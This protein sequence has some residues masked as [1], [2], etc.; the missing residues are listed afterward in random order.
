[1]LRIRNNF[2]L[3]M[4]LTLFLGMEVGWSQTVEAENEIKLSRKARKGSLASFQRADNGDITLLY[5]TRKK[6]KS[7]QYEVYVIDGK[8]YEQKSHETK[9]VSVDDFKAEF[10]T[11][12][13]VKEEYSETGIAVKGYLPEAG[14]FNVGN[15]SAG[16]QIVGAYRAAFAQVFKGLELQKFRIDYEFNWEEG[17]YYYSVEELDDINPRYGEDELKLEHYDNYQVEQNGEYHL[18]VLAGERSPVGF[19]AARSGNLDPDQVKKNL[20]LLTFNP[21][22][23]MTSDVELFYDDPYTYRHGNF[24]NGNT[25]YAM[26]LTAP[27][28]K[29]QGTESDAELVIANLDGDIDERIRFSVKQAR[30]N[31]INIFASDDAYYVYGGAAVEKAGQFDSFQLAKI[32]KNGMASTSITSNEKI[33]DSAKGDPDSPYGETTGLF[34]NWEVNYH[35]M[36]QHVTSS[37]EFILGGQVAKYKDDKKKILDLYMLHFD[38]NQNFVTQY[39]FEPEEDDALSQQKIVESSSGIKWLVYSAGHI[40][41]QGYGGYTISTPWYYPRI[42]T[43]DLG[44]R[45]VSKFENIGDGDYYVSE[46]N[47]I[48]YDLQNENVLYF[49]KDKREKKIWF[50]RVKL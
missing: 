35:P 22:G 36:I 14:K 12:K 43:I 29:V 19:K 17:S 25:Q 37:G 11:F 10:G 13:T 4:V 45:S 1:M 23:K 7:V 5:I 40:D 20:H 3:L 30:W 32:G 39:A 31:I 47:G 15:A 26:V 33:Y 21:Q 9:K 16:G 8:T 38:A 6:R 18:V 24:I 44:N 49:G 34:S 46:S 27:E 50:S 42:A 41:V 48:M 2:L 28:A